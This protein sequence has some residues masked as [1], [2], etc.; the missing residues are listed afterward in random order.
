MFS[1]CTPQFLEHRLEW[2]E[3]QS[4]HHLI[5]EIDYQATANGTIVCRD[6]FRAT[7]ADRATISKQDSITTLLANLDCAG[8]VPATVG[9]CWWR[10]PRASLRSHRRR[11][12]SSARG[13]IGGTL[14]NIRLGPTATLVG[15]TARF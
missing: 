1:S 2:F 3:I 4:A 7:T 10:R 14:G 11:C 9:A 5:G 13:P 8:C 6:G 15:I 12:S